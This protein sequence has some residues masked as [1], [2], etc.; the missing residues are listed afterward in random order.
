MGDRVG[1]PGSRSG[2]GK[3]MEKGSWEERKV[4]KVGKKAAGNGKEFF[5][6]DGLFG[7]THLLSLLS[8]HL[9]LYFQF[10]CY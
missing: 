10:R 5:E 1:Y 6:E 8:R 2:M 3:D 9:S 4:W 7:G